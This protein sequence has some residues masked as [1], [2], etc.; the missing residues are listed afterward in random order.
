M[1]DPFVVSRITFKTT[2]LVDADNQFHNAI[3]IWDAKKKADEAGLQLVC[4]NLPPMQSNELPLCKVIDFGKWKYANDKQQ[5]KI[6]L[7]QRHEVKEVRFSPHISD[8]DIFHKVKHAKEFLEEGHTV[9]LFMRVMGR[10]LA[11]M[12]LAE[13]KMT[14]ILSDLSSVGKMVSRKT[15]GGQIV[16]KMVKN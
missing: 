14:K 4:F 12:D 7:E 3:S 6:Q 1:N 5:K 11:H 8:N 2:K 13:G 10:D 16:A 9:I 15:E